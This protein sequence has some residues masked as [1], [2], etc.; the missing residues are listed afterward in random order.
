MDPTILGS[1]GDLLVWRVREDQNAKLVLVPSAEE[2]Q[3]TVFGMSSD[4][5]SSL[6]DFG[7]HFF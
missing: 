7:D 6:D 5:A 1:L 4:S 3:H 2:V